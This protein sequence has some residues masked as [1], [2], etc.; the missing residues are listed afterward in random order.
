MRDLTQENRCDTISSEELLTPKE[1]KLIEKLR[2][3]PF[4][5]VV[6][7]MQDGQPYRVEKITESFML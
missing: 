4:G 6:I 3:I 5:Q 1:K 7:F 2:T